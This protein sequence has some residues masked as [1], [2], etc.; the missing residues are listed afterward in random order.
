M[1][2]DP[3]LYRYTTEVVPSLVPSVEKF[4]ICLSCSECIGTQNNCCTNVINSV[5]HASSVNLVSTA[6]QDHIEVIICTDQDHFDKS[7]L[8]NKIVQKFVD[9]YS[10]VYICYTVHYV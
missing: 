9:T 5:C 4:Q 2:L 8:V 1:P 3:L 6:Q 7:I 10:Y